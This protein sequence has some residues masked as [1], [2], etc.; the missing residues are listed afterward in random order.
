MHNKLTKIRKK[1]ISDFNQQWN[2]FQKSPG[3]YGSPE[4][5]QDIFGPLIKIESLKQATVIEI[6]SGTGRIAEMILKNGVSYVWCIEPAINAFN[7]LCENL[8]NYSNFS[9][10]NILGDEIPA[11]CLADLVISIGVIHHIKDPGSTL[12]CAFDRTK[13]G[14]K[15]FIWVYGCEGNAL[16]LFIFRIVHFFTKSMEHNKILWLA[17]FLKFPLNLYGRLCKKNPLPMRNYFINVVN[18]WDE[19]VKTLTIYDQLN[20]EYVK[21]YK[22]DEIIQEMIR[23]GFSNVKSYHRH[24][25]SWSLLAEK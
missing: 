8:K 19:E 23:A 1:T 22:R 14:G 5:L 9:A 12:R 2:F 24:G 17:K 4:F 6:G 25:Y 10:L 16:Y 7:I 3:L 20:P 11:E 15:C 21:Y 13:V 18:L